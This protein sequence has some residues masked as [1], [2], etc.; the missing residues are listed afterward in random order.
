MEPHKAAELRV[1]C[2]YFFANREKIKRSQKSNQS[3]NGERSS[4]PTPCA[5]CSPPE[6]G[7]TSSACRA[8]GAAAWLGLRPGESRRDPRAGGTRSGSPSRQ[9]SGGVPRTPHRARGTATSRAVRRARRPRG[10]APASAPP[11]GPLPGLPRGP[12]GRGAGGGEQAGGRGPLSP[13]P[14]AAR[15]GRP[16]RERSSRTPLAQRIL[17][18]ERRIL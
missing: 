13:R 3:I 16:N 4:P 7:R 11:P 12:G 18:R 14:A 1:C 2:F 8:A 15:P 10:W 6:R 9:G 5:A 17:G